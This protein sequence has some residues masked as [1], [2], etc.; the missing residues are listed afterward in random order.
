MV[1][2]GTNPSGAVPPSTASFVKE[3]YTTSKVGQRVR[4][5]RERQKH[6]T[7]GLIEQLLAVATRAMG[8]LKIL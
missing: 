4:E 5:T 3:I 6:I 7:H 2:Q 1:T 8:E